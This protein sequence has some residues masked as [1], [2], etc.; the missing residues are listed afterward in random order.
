[1]V[2]LTAA[3]T[4]VTAAAAAAAADDDDDASNDSMVPCN[5]IYERV[6]IRTTDAYWR[7]EWGTLMQK[8]NTNMRLNVLSVLGT[9]LNQ[10]QSACH[11]PCIC[12]YLA[13]H[14]TLGHRRHHR[15]H[16]GDWLQLIATVTLR[17]SSQQMSPPASA[18]IDSSLQ[19]ASILLYTALPYHANEQ[20]HA[21][22]CGV[23]SKPLYSL[24]Q[25]LIIIIIIIQIR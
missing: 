19:S 12:T 7:L 13:P 14:I 16:H 20:S 25:S 10:A 6:I 8:N 2:Y 21:T 11:Q 23:R 3:V 18:A 4:C 1:M 9:W 15:H 22:R 17:Q 5:L 24:S